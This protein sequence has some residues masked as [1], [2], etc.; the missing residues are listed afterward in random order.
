MNDLG[1]ILL[2]TRVVAVLGAHPEPHRPAFYV[3]DYLFSMGYRV[4]PVNPLFVG[5]VLWGVPVVARLT[6]LTEPVDL[7]DV[8]R[9]SEHL[10]AHVDEVLAM[11]PPPRV[12]W[13]QSGIRNDLVAARWKAAGLTVVSDRCTLAEHRARRL[14]RVA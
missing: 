8:F 9:R 4:L 13:L 3:P 6:D 1:R 11:N 5:R 7:V 14:P 10:P 2:D 12:V